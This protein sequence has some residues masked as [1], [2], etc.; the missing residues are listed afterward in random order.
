M[1][2]KTLA[3][4]PVGRV[5]QTQQKAVLRIHLYVTGE[6]HRLL[7]EFGNTAR[8]IVGRVA[9]ADGVL[10]GLGLVKAKQSI[11][12]EW[13]R[14]FDE[15]RSLF[16]TVRTAAVSLPFGTLAVYQQ[17]WVKPIV[18]K[19]VDERRT[20]QNA[21]R[22]MQE[23]KTAIDFVFNPQLKA[24]RE[25]ADKRIYQDGLKL[26]QRVWNLQ[27]DALK[28]INATLDTGVAN[29]MSAL[30][31]A[32][33]LE[34]WLGAGQDCP[35]WTTTRLYGLTKKD[36]A[37]GDR[38]GLKSGG[39]CAGQGVAYKALR[40]ARN[41]IQAIHHMATDHVMAVMPWVEGEQIVLSPGHP[42]DD[43]CDEVA[44]GGENGDGVYPKGT[45]ELPLHPQCICM[46]V[47]VQMGEDDFADRL[48]G[49]M[50]GSE[51]WPGMDQFANAIGGDVNVDL[52]TSQTAQHLAQWAFEDP[53]KF[54]G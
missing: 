20:T 22:R 45:I 35:R 41:E 1:S 53:A 44:T 19:T 46:K 14:T 43:E 27:Q 5:W 49:W 18:D 16:E 25:A 40:L 54:I 24:L 33:E 29:G 23:A 48:R 21:G 38:A 13:K 37:S 8:A 26:S 12:L 30:D 50:M 32:K 4:I 10:D 2:T 31:I 28:G 34:Q 52:T 9:G 15:W 47:A 6:T 7:L 39:D 51:A 42:V 11:A 17:Q 3:D 36:I